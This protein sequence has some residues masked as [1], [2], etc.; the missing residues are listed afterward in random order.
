M[1]VSEMHRILIVD[2]EPSICE[3]LPL[4][5][6]SHE[7]TVDIAMNGESGVQLGCTGKYAVLIVDLSLPDMNG[8]EVIRR[9]RSQHPE[10]IAIVITAYSSEETRSE[11]RQNGVA[12]FL[13]KPFAMDAIKSA[14]TQALVERHSGESVG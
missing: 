11:A 1:G 5:L 12:H 14:V 2:D 3:A 10:T 13:E 9:I 6:A 8:I 7:V 4:G